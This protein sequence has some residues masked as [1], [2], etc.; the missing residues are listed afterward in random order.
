MTRI[1]LLEINLSAL[2]KDLRK[3]KRTW[4]ERRPLQRAVVRSVA[5][6]PLDSA[7]RLGPPEV[8]SGRIQYY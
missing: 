5:I 6:D 1:E 4:P 3:L 2:A 8:P 7:R